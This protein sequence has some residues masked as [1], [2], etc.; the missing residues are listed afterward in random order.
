MDAFA[1]CVLTDPIPPVPV[2][3]QAVPLRGGSQGEECGTARP[4][5]NEPA[6]LRSSVSDS[7]G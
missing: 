2:L 4:R 3:D 1:T 7:H 5:M 6:E